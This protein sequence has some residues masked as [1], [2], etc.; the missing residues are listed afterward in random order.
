MA[1]DYG[2][3]SIVYMLTSGT[4]PYVLA[5]SII[6]PAVLA[7]LLLRQPR[8]SAKATAARGGREARRPSVVEDESPGSLHEEPWCPRFE[9]KDWREADDIPGCPWDFEGCETVVD[10]L[11]RIWCEALPGEL[12]PAFE[13]L[14]IKVR[15]LQVARMAVSFPRE[16]VRHA[17]IYT[18]QT[19]AELFGGDPLPRGRAPAAP[20][21]QANAGLWQR[22]SG[23]QG[24]RTSAG[25]SGPA[26]L[27]SHLAPFFHIHDGFGVLLSTRHLPLLLC[28]PD[29]S[30]D[31]SCFYV[32]PVRG[33]EAI[34]RHPHLFRFARVDRNCVACVHYHEEFAG[35]VY[36][37]STGELVEEEEAP[38]AFIA[39]TVS[40]IAGQRVVPPAYLGGPGAFGVTA[41]EGLHH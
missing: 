34:K 3:P 11:G 19:G 24:G 30:V 31:G 25:Q 8:R 28:S 14:K 37:E 23:P 41:C 7:T 15:G 32:Y 6:L 29:D 20:A 2:S 17:I 26:S 35:I 18:L 27:P 16:E 13:V 38:L 9:V 5:L 33:L 36:A 4:L 10:A 21:A 22:R 12:E 1:W 40:N 39:D